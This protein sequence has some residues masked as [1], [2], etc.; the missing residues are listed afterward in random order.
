M[1]EWN[2]LPVVV[3][4]SPRRLYEYLKEAIEG[5]DAKIK[6]TADTPTQGEN[7]DTPPQNNEGGDTPQ[8]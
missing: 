5:V 7:V 3:R 6:D 8:E 1:E 4:R 2:E